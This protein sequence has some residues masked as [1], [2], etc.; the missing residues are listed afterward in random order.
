MATLRQGLKRHL[1]ADSVVVEAG[2]HR[3][4]VTVQLADLWP[5]GEIHAFEPIP[6]L[7]DDLRRRTAGR[8]NVKTYPMA[9]GPDEKVQSMWVG[10][11]GD[12]AS[13]S[14]LPPK[15]HLDVY[16]DISFERT[17][18]VDVT[19]LAGWAEREKIDRL[20]GLWL[21]MQGYELAA[22]KGAGGLLATT[23]ALVL[24]ISAVELYEGC[25]LWP[26]VRTWLEGAGFH[27]EEE[28]WHG[29]KAYG[30]ALAVRLG[31]GR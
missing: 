25:P 9:L 8:P 4:I 21:D 10:G 5:E 18:P 12:D 2:A 22:L 17:V 27:I 23:S 16:P 30:D 20:D 3:G 28:V 1:P 11:G 6:E 7:Y 24:E 13:S 14:L 26:E 31:A 15:A 19:T 29:P